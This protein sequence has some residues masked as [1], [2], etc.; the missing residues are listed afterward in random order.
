M[1]YFENYYLNMLV[2]FLYVFLLFGLTIPANLYG[3]SLYLTVR[4]NS[5]TETKTIDSISYQKIFENFLNLQNEVDD[6]KKKL[7]KT[8]YI[9]SELIELKKQNDSTYVALFHLNH[10]YENVRVYFDT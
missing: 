1:R 7:L 5:E 6:L 8:G 10:Y 4:S 2:K 3:Q 9:E